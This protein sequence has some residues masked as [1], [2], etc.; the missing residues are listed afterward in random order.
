MVIQYRLNDKEKEED[1]ILYNMMK[2][3]LFITIIIASVSFMAPSK[4]AACSCAEL[5]SVEDSLERSEAV[6][7][8]KV[9]EIKELKNTS[10]YM[11]KSVKFEVNKVWKGRSESLIVIYTGI[12]GGDCGYAFVE[13]KEYLV[14]AN[15]TTMYDNVK[16]LTTISCDRTALIS[17]AQ[18]DLSILGEGEAPTI[19]IQMVDDSERSYQFIW[20]II[21][22]IVVVGGAVFFLRKKM[23]R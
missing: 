19:K 5:A 21:I 16:E 6:F 9:L 3:L 23:R 13:G 15:S 7:S 17:Q 18:E 20:I 2:F 1:D 10:G 4:A 8:G 12:G 14:Y 11:R 22:S